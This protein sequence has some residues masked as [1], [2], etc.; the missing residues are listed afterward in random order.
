MNRF[1]WDLRY[2][3]ASGA[4]GDP[5]NAQAARG[6]Q[7]LPG[8]YQVRVTVAGQH[9]TQPLKIVLDPR[10]TATPSDL[11]RQFDLAMRIAKEFG[12]ATDATQQIGSLRRQLADAKSKA[13][14]N[15]A[16]P[17]LIASLDAEAEKI[18]GA[19]G[20]NAEAP[21]SGLNAVR[22]QLNA[23]LNV[24]DSADR[25]PPAQAYALFDQANRDL[26]AQLAA[27]NSLKSGK[28]IELNRSL[29][30]QNLLRVELQEK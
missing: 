23:V 28:L 20:R 21:P 7:A 12:R 6:P 3:T 24:V 1:V 10:S 22:S 11:A 13:S 8:T 17:A 5:E 26:A 30:D 14:G 25:T 19:G 18:A 4:T 2:P 27:W 29:Q 15:S 16:L 9:F